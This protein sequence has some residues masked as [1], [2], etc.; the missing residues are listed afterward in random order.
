MPASVQEEHREQAVRLLSTAFASD[1]LTM[2]QLEERLA[3]VYT[4][5]SLAEL[6]LLLVDPEDSSRSLAQEIVAT[7]LAS[8]SIVP[9]RG[10]AVAIMGGFR[11]RGQWIVPRHLKVTAIMGGGELDLRDVRFSPGITEIEIFTLWGGVEIYVPDGVR[12]DVVGMAVMGGFELNGG[13]VSEDPSAP[14]LRVSGLAVMGGVE[15][16]RKRSGREGQKRYRE[17]IKRAER[18]RRKGRRDR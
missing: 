9:E 15:V 17:A 16:K 18:I 11:R 10:V 14:V 1:R 6:E 3:A 13:G 5:R 4:A 8:P 2:E 12:V 7:R